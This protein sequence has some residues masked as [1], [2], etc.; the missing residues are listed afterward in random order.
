MKL[1][2][3]I[4]EFYSSNFFSLVDQFLR[5]WLNRVWG[6]GELKIAKEKGWLYFAEERETIWKAKSNTEG[7]LGELIRI[8]KNKIK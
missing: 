7:D 2:S 5:H 8:L 1:F 4:S 6:N 3:V